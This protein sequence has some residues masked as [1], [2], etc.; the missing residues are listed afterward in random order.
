M[1]LK[2]TSR[3]EMMLLGRKEGQKDQREG[4]NEGKKD[5]ILGIN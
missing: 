3:G 4:G 1:V 2:K 5:L